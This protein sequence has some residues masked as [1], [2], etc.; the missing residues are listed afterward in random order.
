M[1][2]QG[3]GFRL[4]VLVLFESYHVAQ[5]IGQLSIDLGIMGGHCGIVGD[6]IANVLPNAVF[7]PI[8]SPGA[9]SVN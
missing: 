4:P 1:Q 6:H 3:A 7:V 9:L 2:K 5:R 8:I